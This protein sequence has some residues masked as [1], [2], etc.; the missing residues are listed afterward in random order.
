MRAILRKIYKYRSL[1]IIILVFIFALVPRFIQLF[2]IHNFF[3]SE[4]GLDYLITKNIVIDHHI[5]LTGGEVGGIGGF[6]KGAFWNYLLSIPFILA[7]GDP[8]G[9]KVFMFIISMATV[10]ASFFITRKFFNLTSA[11]I[12]S[13]F[14][15]MSPYLLY[16]SG[17]I[18]PPFAT[19]ILIA[20]LIYLFL[21]FFNGEKKYLLFSFFIIGL[22]SHFEVA[23]S[24]VLIVQFL[25]I[26]I[27]AL[28]KKY[29]SI[30]IFLLS[31]FA[32]LLTLLPIFIFDISH[33][34]YNTKGVLKMFQ[35]P[36]KHKSSINIFEDRIQTFS[37]NFQS[38]LTPHRIVSPILF[39][40]LYLGAFFY[41]KDIKN[42]W[43]NKILVSYFLISPIFSFILFLFYPGIMSAWWL[44]YLTVF[45]CFLFGI[46]AG[47]FMQ[48]KYLN[49]IIAVLFLSLLKAFLWNTFVAYKSD[50]YFPQKTNIIAQIEPIDFIYKDANKLPFKVLFLRSTSVK[51]DDLDYLLWWRGQGHRPIS[52]KSKL[53]YAVIEKDKNKSLASFKNSLEKINGNL[54]ETKELGNY[55]VEKYVLK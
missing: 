38:T 49:I 12:V 9:G 33:N 19:P 50:F 8:F 41:L 51:T 53:L 30:R 34:F 25:I 24:A 46:L 31:I 11:L 27:I 6:S 22:I 29:I 54:I 47:Y 48:K 18:W 28:F 5:L 36:T 39:I 42:K 40:F 16:Q 4:Q 2:N 32:F 35:T 14:L 44:I 55:V 3:G 52:G 23:I 1:L 7:K 37:W 21:K 26:A 20:L 15:A 45:Y 13:F 17:N 43:R 10:V